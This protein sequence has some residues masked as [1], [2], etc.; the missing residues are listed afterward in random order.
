MIKKY[1]I[2][3]KLVAC[4]GAVNIDRIYKCKNTHIMRD[5]NIS[6]LSES[7]GGVMY[8]ITSSLNSLLCKTKLISFIGDDK[9]SAMIIKHLSKIGINISSIK[10]IKNQKTG[11]YTAIQDKS[12]EIIIGVN[13]MSII[14]EIKPQFIEKII[15]NTFAKTW[16]IDSNFKREPIEKIIY[17]LKN[18]KLIATAVSVYKAPRLKPALKYLDY[19]FLNQDELFALAPKEK[20]I[21]KAIDKILK[22]G[23]KNIFVTLGSRGAIAASGTEYIKKKNYPTKIIDLN[24]AGDAFCGSAIA[25]IQK[26]L[27]LKYTLDYALSTSSLIAEVKGSIRSNLTN[28]LITDKIKKFS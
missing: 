15:N 22:L 12:G 11:S 7:V 26:E 21:R 24:G 14:E 3:S 27:P 8:N 5:S 23:T 17:L 19:L 6:D 13:E 18:K 4:L 20:N 2:E 25:C 16:V 10:K 1:P 28:K 9:E